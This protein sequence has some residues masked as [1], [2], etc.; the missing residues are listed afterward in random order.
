MK[1][2][3]SFWSFILRFGFSAGILWFIFSKIDMGGTIELI[4]TAEI[5]YI[6]LSLAIFL[7][8]HAFL[9]VRWSIFMQAMNL[10]FRVLTAAR[11]FFIGLFCNLFLPTAIGGD[12]VKAAGIARETHNKT[13]VVA[14]V[15]LDRLSG[16]AGIVIVAVT[17]FVLG[18]GIIRNIYLGIPVL[19]LALGCLTI[20]FMLFN[21]KIYAFGCRIFDPF[22]KLKKALM[23]MHK[24]VLLIRKRPAKG[25]QAIAISCF[26]QGVF[27][28][29]YYYAAK[30]LHQDIP[31]VYFW[32]FV[33]LIC[34]ICSLPSIGGL[35]VREAGTAYL[36]SKIGV[37]PGIAVSISL[38]NFL[39]MVFAGAIGGVILMVTGFKLSEAAV[40]DTGVA[41]ETIL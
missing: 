33:P 31:V 16:F 22:P 2:L 15:L 3:N 39:F 29:T 21:E 14:S 6:L 35:G 34:V 32:V 37:E 26:T 17:A 12:I 13:A 30:G 24:D 27:A 5:N 4:K 23:D 18:F 9:L 8:L 10:K 11:Y 36:F 41:S 38:L 20:A 7:L 25:W 19:I 28:L 1:K 40:Q